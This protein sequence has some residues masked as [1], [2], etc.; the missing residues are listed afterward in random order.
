[1]GKTEKQ[2]RRKIKKTHK[3]RKTFRKKN[4]KMIAG[5]KSSHLCSDAKGTCNLFDKHYTENGK[6]NETWDTCIKMNGINNNIIYVTSQNVLIKSIES[7]QVPEFIVKLPNETDNV[8]CK[9]MIEDKYVGCFLK[10]CGEWYVIMRLFGKTLNTGVLARTEGNK[11]FYKIDGITINANNPEMDDGLFLFQTN[12]FEETPDTTRFSTS[13]TKIVKLKDGHFKNINKSS[14]V[15]KVL[16]R[17][18]QEKLIANSVK[19]Q[20]V[21]QVI[22]GVGD[23]IFKF[24]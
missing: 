3:K 8:P 4:Q 14:D 19:H 16:Q 6:V 17:F 2:R 18:R 20:L 9:I 15:F 5:N 1:M 10:V 22:S 7:I 12:S 11:V 13:K 21:D 24:W 23:E